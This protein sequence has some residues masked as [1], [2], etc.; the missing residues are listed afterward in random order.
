MVTVDQDT[1]TVNVTMEPV[2]D[3]PTFTK[4]P[5]QVVDENAGT[6]SITNWATDISSGC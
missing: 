3:R 5:D 2:N 1:V 6:Q 4:G